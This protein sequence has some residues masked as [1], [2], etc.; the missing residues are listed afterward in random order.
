MIK[1]IGAVAE[2]ELNNYT[3]TNAEPITSMHWQQQGLTGNN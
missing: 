1:M 2:S 3:N